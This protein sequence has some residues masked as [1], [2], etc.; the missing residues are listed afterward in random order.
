MDK[1]NTG[2]SVSV[3]LA[4]FNCSSGWEGGG[5]GGEGGGGGQGNEV[6][7]PFLQSK[8]CRYSKHYEN[9]PIQIY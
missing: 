4:F 6:E 9:M 3:K 2:A 8:N 1:S 7:W 5:G